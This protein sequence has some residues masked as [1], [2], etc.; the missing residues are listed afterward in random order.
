MLIKL[1]SRAA[2]PLVDSTSE[3][4]LA[5][6]FFLLIIACSCLENGDLYGIFYR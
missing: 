1:H 5:F 3:R 2:R 6:D 4:P